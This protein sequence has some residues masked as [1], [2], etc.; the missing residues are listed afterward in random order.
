MLIQLS[1]DTV[2]RVQDFMKKYYDKDLENLKDYSVAVEK[3][4][5]DFLLEN[6]NPK[7]NLEIKL[8][9]AGF[10]EFSDIYEEKDS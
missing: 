10:E 5:S 9:R 7:E 4:V 3:C 8:T 6:L 1:N 2:K